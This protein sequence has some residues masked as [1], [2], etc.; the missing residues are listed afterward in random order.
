MLLPLELWQGRSLLRV[1]LLLEGKLV[2][3]GRVNAK[4]KL[5]GRR[6]LLDTG[7]SFSLWPHRSSA[8]T[9]GPLISG[10]SGAAIQCWGDK[11]FS[12]RFFNRTYKWN[13]LLADVSIPIIGID[14]L[15][16]FSLLVHTMTGRLLDVGGSPAPDLSASPPSLVLSSG[17]ASG[18]T[19]GPPAFSSQG[20]K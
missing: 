15:Q 6:F 18:T 19:G 16:H 20:Y 2:P 9:S 8:P 7:A 3:P 4:C 14:F 13:F 17:P 1:A 10:P 5:S 12:V 11:P